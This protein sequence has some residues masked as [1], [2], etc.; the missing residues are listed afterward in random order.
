MNKYIFLTFFL[1]LYSLFFIL[2]TDVHAV[3]M[4]SPRYQIFFGTIGSGGA[5]ASSTNY[6]LRETIGQ[7]AALD[8]ERRGFVVFA[9]LQ[10][11]V[12]DTPLTLTI[13]NGSVDL[14]ISSPNKF[15]A[16]SVDISVLSNHRPYQLT[17]AAD[18]SL[19]TLGG[20]AIP[21]T[22]CDEQA[23]CTALT[24]S[25]WNNTSS[26][27]FGYSLKGEDIPTDFKQGNFFRPFPDAQ[28]NMQSAIIMGNRNPLGLR[29]STLI[30]KLNVS[31]V[32][33]VGSYQTNIELIAL[34]GL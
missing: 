14:S 12:E 26:I 29:K 1:I 9:G 24:A 5:A 18:G 19:K 10:N 3:D 33:N 25:A 2:Y 20:V 21:T 7:T 32:Q 30:L 16:G 15:A 13:S 11:Y 4:Q 8:F 28:Q 6:R 31:P 34:P 22:S 23:P 27:G 17:T